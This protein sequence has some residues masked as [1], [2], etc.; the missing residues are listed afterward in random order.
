MSHILIQHY[1]TDEDKEIIMD[2][3]KYDFPLSMMIG[4]K[5]EHIVRCKDC[6]YRKAVTNGRSTHE[7]YYCGF[8]YERCDPYEMTRNASDPNYFCAD[9]KRR[10]ENE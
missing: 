7:E 1:L 5:D 10:S 3:L 8:E 6:R 9:A 2:C 4:N